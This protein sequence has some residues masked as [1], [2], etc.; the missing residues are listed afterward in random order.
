MKVSFLFFLIVFSSKAD[1]VFGQN[2][3]L[4]DYIQQTY[5]PIVCT[6]PSYF[7]KTRTDSSLVITKESNIQFEINCIK[8]REFTFKVNGQYIDTVYSGNSESDAVEVNEIILDT[9]DIKSFTTESHYFFILPISNEGCNGKACE[10][11]MYYLICFSKNGLHPAAYFFLSDEK[12]GVNFYSVNGELFYL[13]ILD[14]F[15]DSSLLKLLNRQRV[16]SRKYDYLFFQKI[17]LNNKNQSWIR[18]KIES[19]VLRAKRDVF[20]IISDYCSFSLL[21]R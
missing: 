4:S 16:N 3:C 11:R 20:G 18:R 14:A 10:I 6:Q 15:Y 2:I 12:D 19:S 17:E 9:S 7:N 13:D 21:K 5:H 1:F 8:N